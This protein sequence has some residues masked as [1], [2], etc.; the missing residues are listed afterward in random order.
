MSQCKED[1]CI[2]MEVLWQVQG[3]PHSVLAAKPCSVLEV[4]ADFPHLTFESKRRPGCR[5]RHI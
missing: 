3:S 5:Q 2:L 1:G 4:R